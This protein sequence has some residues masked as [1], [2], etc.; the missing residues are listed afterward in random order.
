[1]GRLSTTLK[2]I[3]PVGLLV[4]AVAVFVALKETRPVAEPAPRLE[5]SWPIAV[6]TVSIGDE[7]PTQRVF[8]TVV[9]GRTV[10]MRSLVAGEVV[11]VGEN[12]RN[13]GIVARGEMLIEIDPFE[14]RIALREIRAQLAEARARL[15]ELRARRDM[16]KAALARER[17]MLGLDER[18]LA[19][20]E[21]LFRRGNVSERALDDSRMALARM[22][23][24]VSGR[25]FSVTAE[26]A[27][28]AQQEATIERLEAEE[29]RVAR[30]LERTRLVAPY[31]G[32]LRGI[33]A[34]MG[35]RLGVNDAVAELI[36]AD[37]LEVAVR[38]S[39]AQYGRVYGSPEGLIGRPV[40]VIW[41]AGRVALTHAARIE[42]VG[43]AVEAASG[44]IEIYARLADSNAASPLRPGNFV[45]VRMSDQVYADVARLPESA[46][47]EGDRVYVVRDGRLEPRDVTVV[48]RM[49]DDML[50]RGA[51]DDGDQVAVTRFTGIGPGLKVEILAP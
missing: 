12:F 42:R 7:Q 2:I 39:D 14:Y 22:R 49:G 16:E 50:V 48:A 47:H 35:R 19:R 21:E 8:G 43:A 33:Q 44:G 9:S 6:A 24:G 37:S 25:E 4:V 36:D 38:L 40:Q 32:F 17:E 30:D 18:Q 11:A 28:V 29:A 51:L 1:M 41:Q 31:N 46:L 20:S 13:G 15:V 3:L 27:R 34:E 23:Q 10:S 26:S 45:E 5:R